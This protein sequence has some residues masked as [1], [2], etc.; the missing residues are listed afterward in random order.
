LDTSRDIPGTEI[1]VKAILA[2]LYI[3]WIHPFGD[4]NGRAARL[5]ELRILLEAGVPMPEMSKFEEP[6]PKGQLRRLSPG[7]VE[8]YHG[9]TD[10][11]LTRDVDA[12]IEM[13]LIKRRPG[14]YLPDKGVIE[15]FLPVMAER[16]DF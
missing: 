13:G 3:A 14:G 8:L 10:K 11:T 15:A 16:P 1:L 9:K 5:M 7:L 12:V 4:G 2:H 6:L